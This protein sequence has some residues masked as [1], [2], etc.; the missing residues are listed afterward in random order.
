MAAA[1][2]R[3][4]G[5]L[6][7]TEDLLLRAL[8][9]PAREIEF[10]RACLLEGEAAVASWQR[11]VALSGNPLDALR[12]DRIGIKRHLPR[13]YVNLAAADAA[14]AH[15][16]PDR[17]LAPYLR[18][19]VAREQLRSHR[20]RAALGE[21]LDA[22]ASAGVHAILLRGTA[23]GETIVAEP[24][25]RH[26]HDADLFVDGSEQHRA[27]AALQ[28]AG[29]Q[30][31]TAQVSHGTLR[32]DHPNG[33]PICL[34]TR[35]LDAAPATLDESHMLARAVAA[36]AAERDARVLCNEDM[37]L[38]VCCHAATHGS[39]RALGWI[40]D[41]VTVIRADGF[42][43][44]RVDPAAWESAGALLAPAFT[45]IDAVV[46]GS[47]PPDVSGRAPA[48]ARSTREMR[49]LCLRA[50]AVSM[51]AGELL[52]HANGIV[53]RATIVVMLI[54][55]LPPKVKWRIRSAWEEKWLK[56]VRRHRSLGPLR[57]AWLRVKPAF[58]RATS[59]GD[60]DRPPT[61]R[62][63]DLS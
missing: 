36:R 3:E 11:W 39:R 4:S 14:P 16:A 5:P 47:V 30:Q 37:L 22:L 57:K 58:G 44:S 62:E 21:A 53:D 60:V 49:A 41:A 19:A 25:L 56:T 40:I 26:S 20:F 17:E 63:R 54:R 50:A 33:L 38:H 27:R 7:R 48:T 34:H 2:T 55:H 8:S 45:V 6:R 52:L 35:L 9:P 23:I 18:T 31:R 10:L 12:G 32:L 1:T 24:W 29:F 13:L 59:T 43:W 51:G 61:W 46:P 28:A 42:D 15:A